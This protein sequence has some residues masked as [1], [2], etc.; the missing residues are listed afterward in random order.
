MK[1]EKF[2]TNQELEYMY[3][4]MDYVPK[5]YKFEEE[6]AIEARRN[7]KIERVDKPIEIPMPFIDGRTETNKGPVCVT[8]DW[9]VK[10]RKK[11]LTK[12]AKERKAVQIEMMQLIAERDRA[13]YKLGKLDMSKKKSS[14]MAVALN[15]KIRDIDAELESLQAITGIRLNQLDRGSKL[16]QFVG[17]LKRV[18][19]KAKRAVKKWWGKHCELITGI[20][21]IVLPVVF[22]AIAKKFVALFA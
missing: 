19:H 22:G 15:T 1:G 21:S 3:D 13:R 18:F 11:E 7:K 12:I 14:K 6:R 17:K 5:I 10:C 20:A 2:M 4:D 16:G 8:K 9:Y